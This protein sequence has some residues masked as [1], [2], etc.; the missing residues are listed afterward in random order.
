MKLL[1]M[2]VAALLMFAAICPFAGSDRNYINLPRPAGFS[3]LPFSDAVLAGNTLYIGGH[4]GLDPKS[5]Q[6][7]ASAEEEAKLAMD[8]TKQTLEAARMTMDDLVS[9]E[10]HC[11]DMSL[12]DAFN[13]V[14]KTYFHGEYPA[15]AFLGSGRLLR[16]AR[17]E[18]LGTAVKRL[19]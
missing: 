1:A 18:V 10:V 16:G 14:Y 19:K 4:I 7:P 15:R 3:G 5:G 12:Y 17:F 2:C 11:S 13:A 9:V 8:S 6:P